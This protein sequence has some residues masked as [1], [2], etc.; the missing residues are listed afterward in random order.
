MLSSWDEAQILARALHAAH[1]DEGPRAAMELAR[2][3]PAEAVA[4]LA[5]AAGLLINPDWS[6]DVP[7]P[8]PDPDVRHAA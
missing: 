4:V 2:N 1:G 3:Q 5:A 6:K 8:E 7:A